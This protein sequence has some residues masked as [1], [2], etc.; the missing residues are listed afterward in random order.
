[1]AERWFAFFA[2]KFPGNFEIQSSFQKGPRQCSLKR[3][4]RCA[5]CIEV[6]VF[7]A[8]GVRYDVQKTKVIIDQAYDDLVKGVPLKKVKETVVPRL[9]V[10]LF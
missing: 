8:G 3:L 9:M 4:G 2:R 7:K 1:M 5:S 6:C 10:R